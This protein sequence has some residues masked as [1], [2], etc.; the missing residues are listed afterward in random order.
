M[1]MVNVRRL[2]VMAFLGAGMLSGIS[3][4]E[5]PLQADTLN[6]AKLPVRWDLQSCIDYALEQ[7]ITIRK[8]VW[9][10]KVHRLT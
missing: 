6:E 1:N 8:T 5:S 9:L 10:R 2:T 3:A 7:N 4:Q